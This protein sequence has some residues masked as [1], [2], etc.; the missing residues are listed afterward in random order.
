MENDGGEESAE[1]AAEMGV[2]GEIFEVALKESFKNAFGESDG[3]GKESGVE[4][5][6][7]EDLEGVLDIFL[8]VVDLESTGEG[9]DGVDGGGSE[10]S[11]ESDDDIKG[12]IERGEE[13]V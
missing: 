4:E 8:R 9:G 7:G 3:G 10:C 2:A 13:I 6:E 12:S 1:V 11:L 5:E